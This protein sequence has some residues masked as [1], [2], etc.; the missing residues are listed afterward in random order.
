[1]KEILIVGSSSF[2]ANAFLKSY[3]KNYKFTL[4]SISK[5]KI[6]FSW[7]KKIINLNKINST[8]IK[9]YLNPP[10]FDAVLFFHA[11]GTKHQKN[12][13][14]LIYSNEMIPK[15]FF[16]FF[17]STNRK[18][19]FIYFGSVSEFNDQ[20][21]DIYAKCKTRTSKYFSV[22]SSK[23]NIQT[24]ILQLF[25]IYGVDENSHRLLSHIKNKI[26]SNRK[27]IIKNPDQKI[28][29]LNVKDFNRALKKIVDKNLNKKFYRYK[30]CYGKKYSVKNVLSFI[31]YKSIF[32]N[33]KK[34]KIVNY[35]IS[36]YKKFNLDFKWKPKINIENGINEYFK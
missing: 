15:L 8:E 2:L 36:G 7:R 12:I 1:M 32:L 14:R 6:E 3:K 24:I 25:Y 22:N 19:K 16:D 28:D 31:N 10:Q 4:I 29:F 26:L 30:L 23:F 18:I 17:K 35:N 9:K 34:L 13:K 5:K 27:I 20:N 11:Y 33:R 21:K